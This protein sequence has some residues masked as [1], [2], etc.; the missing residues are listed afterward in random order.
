M[1]DSSSFALP[2][3]ELSMADPDPG[4]TAEW[5]ESFEVLVA[6]H[7]PSRAR[8]ILDMLAESAHAQHIGWS[9]ASG[10]P[11]VN[12]IAVDAQPAFPGDLAIEEKLA[13]LM[14]WNALAMVVRA[15]HSYGELGGHVA[16]YASAADL[17]EAGFNHF[18]HAQKCNARWRPGVP[19]SRTVRP[20]S[21]PVPTSKGA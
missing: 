10:T 17:F 20:A 15:N 1:T 16:S 12:T 11:Y 6:T 9:P 3:I 5:R 4:E 13:S 18:F 19:S 21:M 8:Q 7:G 2:A 14:R